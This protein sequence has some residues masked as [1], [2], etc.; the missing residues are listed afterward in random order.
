[1]SA[2]AGARQWASMGAVCPQVGYAG[3][4]RVAVPWPSFVRIQ[5]WQLCA[6]RWT[7]PRPGGAGRSRGAAA[8][9][10]RARGLLTAPRE[11]C[12]FP[13]PLSRA[14]PFRAILFSGCVAVGKLID[15]SDLL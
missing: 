14:F 6:E 9:G 13:M 7:L 4:T 2:E 15:F 10:P 12:R 11:V 3:D 1:M 5:W 8:G